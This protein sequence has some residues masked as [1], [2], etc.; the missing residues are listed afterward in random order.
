MQHSVIAICSTFLFLLF[1]V[2]RGKSEPSS[3]P[4]RKSFWSSKFFKPNN[5]RKTKTIDN[6][7][8]EPI[9]QAVRIMKYDRAEDER[10]AISALNILDQETPLKWYRLDDG[11]MGGQSETLHVCLDDGSLH[12]TGQ[13]NTNGGGFCSIRSPLSEGLPKDATA[14]RLQFRGDGKTYKLLLSDGTRSSVGP[15]K[16]SPSWQC[17]IP[18]KNMDNGAKNVGGREEEEITIPFSSLKPSWGPRPATKQEAVQFDAGSMRQ[19]GFML[20]L[21]RSDGSNNPVETFGSGIFPL[22]FQVSS[23]ELIIGPK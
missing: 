6:E 4:G 12:F 17:D 7:N 15:S 18:T 3:T 9:G 2:Q 20:S 5:W 14:I 21:K 22:S 1:A 11:V 16:R 23:I 8:K 10:N 19:I 13:I